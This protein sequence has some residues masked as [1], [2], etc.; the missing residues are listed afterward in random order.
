MKN[1]YW[2]KHY[3]PL[4]WS[5]FTQAAFFRVPRVAQVVLTERERLPTTGPNAPLNPSDVGRRRE[6]PCHG[7]SGATPTRRLWHT[8][9]HCLPVAGH[10]YPVLWKTNWLFWKR[11]GWAKLHEGWCTYPLCMPS[12]LCNGPRVY[13][14]HLAWEIPPLLFPQ[15][16]RCRTKG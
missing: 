9:V 14:L 13:R 5:K 11:C 6:C 15:I 4:G 7:R 16:F 8:L 2:K 3:E 10:Q 12:V 1:Y